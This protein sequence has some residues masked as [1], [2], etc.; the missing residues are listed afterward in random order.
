MSGPED[1]DPSKVYKA[2]VAAI[3]AGQPRSS[4][5]PAAPLELVLQDRRLVTALDQLAPVER[6]HLDRMFRDPDLETALR[7]GVEDFPIDLELASLVDD[8]GALRYRLYAMNFGAVYVMEPE[9]FT[10]VAF[11]SQ[12]HVEHWHADQRDLFW[13][14]DRALRRPGHGLNQ[15]LHFCW[16]DEA[17]WARIADKPRGTVASEPYIVR[18][19]AESSS[20]R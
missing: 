16:A 7:D 8:K 17:C 12:H 5:Q 6:A 19:M 15:P 10:C 2:Q 13:A 20:Q 11:A 3:V 1:S 14:I 18:A 4:Y 9:G